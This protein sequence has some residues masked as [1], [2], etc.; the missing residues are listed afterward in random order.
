LRELS[1]T[2][3]RSMRWRGMDD[4]PSSQ[5]LASQTVGRLTSQFE[6]TLNCID[7]DPNQFH[8]ARI[9]GRRLRY[10][11][12]LLGGVFPQ[13]VVDTICRRLTEIQDEL[14]RVNDDATALRHLRDW[15]AECNDDSVRRTLHVLVVRAESAVAA[16]VA[17]VSDVVPREAPEVIAQLRELNPLGVAM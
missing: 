11:L 16:R 8:R 1:R 14:G 4:A 6:E 9:C 13:E 5:Q 10:T 3:V 2:L 17:S 15:L 7:S 12:E